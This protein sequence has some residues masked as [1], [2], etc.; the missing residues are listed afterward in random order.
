MADYYNLTNITHNY[1]LYEFTKT[2][3]T[4]T[5]NYLGIMILL[6]IFIILII[7]FKNYGTRSALMSASWI[8]TLLASLLFIAGL[9]TYD[10]L[11]LCI[12]ITILVIFAYNLSE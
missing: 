3:N 5:D 10:I 11:L 6:V 2:V 1:N 8:V 9:V 7:A 12:I 4:L